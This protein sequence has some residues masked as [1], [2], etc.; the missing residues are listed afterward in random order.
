MEKEGKCY[1]YKERRGNY[2][3]NKGQAENLFVVALK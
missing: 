3:K 2:E 1:K